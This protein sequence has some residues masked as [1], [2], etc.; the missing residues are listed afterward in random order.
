M[1]LKRWITIAALCIIVILGVAAYAANSNGFW[2][3]LGMKLAVIWHNDQDMRVIAKIGPEEV[4]QG[5]VELTKVW[6]SAQGKAVNR[7][8]VL[9]DLISHKILVSEAKKRGLFPSKEEVLTYMDQLTDQ[10][11]Q[12]QMPKIAKE[13]G[14][15]I[16]AESMARVKDFFA[17]LEKGGI[18]EEQYWRNKAV[19]R[20]YR[21]GMAIGKLRAELAKEW[22]FTRE[23]MVTPQGMVDFEKKL[24]EF[25]SARRKVTKVE[26]LDNAAFQN[27]PR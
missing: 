9:D 4:T 25:V 23:E 11:R 22:G 6:L 7:R 21:E 14:I 26:I 19:I 5:E 15:E 1:I 3:S 16:D 20:R 12:M 10:M 17:G 2:E 13:K 27:L 8:A 24:R 18:P